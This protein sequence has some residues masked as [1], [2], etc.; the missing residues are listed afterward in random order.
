MDRDRIEPTLYSAFNDA[1]VRLVLEPH[2]GTLA[3]S[4]FDT[5]NRGA[6]RHIMHIRAH[7]PRMIETDD[8]SLLPDGT[9]WSSVMAEALSKGIA[10]L[11]QHLGDT[12]FQENWS[13]GAVHKTEPRH[14]L[15]GAFPDLGEL[16]D[17]PSVEAH[18]SWD[19]P[20]AGGYSIDPYTITV[21]SVNRYIYDMSDL[22]NSRWVI[23]L[24]SSGHP[25]SPHFADQADI[26][27]D[28]RTIPMLY[29][30]KV[31]ER[32]AETHQRLS[33]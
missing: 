11:R 4:A 15:S 17:P 16:L 1:L 32:E 33:P 23:P 14:T 21:L 8:R 6:G 12:P 30:W 24:G 18:G 29:D 10:Y 28:V 19:T 31:I 3:A 13:W 25:G 20:L 27:A 22:R 5:P 2:L 9:D 26:W 7:I